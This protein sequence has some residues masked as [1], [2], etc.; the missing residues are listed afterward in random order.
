MEYVAGVDSGSTT[1]K[2]VVLRDGELAGQYVVSTGANSRR[3]FEKAFER[4][5]EHLKVHPFQIKFVVSTGYGRAGI[6]LA[7]RTVSEITCHARGVR[8]LFPS[9]EVIIDIGGQDFKVIRL[10]KGGRVV[11]FAMNDKCAAGT[12]RYLEL[13][14]RVFE[15]DLET[16]G[17][18]GGTGLEAVEIANVCTVFAETEVIAHISRGTEETKIIAGIFN[19]VAKRVHSLAKQLIMEAREI[20][21]TGGVAKNAGIVG[22]LERML[23]Q[24]VKVPFEP[25]ITGALGAALF[26]WEDIIRRSQYESGI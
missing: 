5:L 8:W 3:A 24:A 22:A 21:F 10:D 20:V 13:M 15:M 14:G 23:G 25:Q 1:T 6:H 4:A 26:A 11:D 17:R 16:F 19:A 18:A 12:G 7:N 9:A 2:L